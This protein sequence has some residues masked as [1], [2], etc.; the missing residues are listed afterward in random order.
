MTTLSCSRVKM[1]YN[2]LDCTSSYWQRRK[3]PLRGIHH[4][5]VHGPRIEE[6]RLLQKETVLIISS[7][8]PDYE[9][10]EVPLGMES[11]VRQGS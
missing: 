4:G 10:N 8:K 3:T 11:F 9:D 7:G 5:H 2:L 6:N 1:E